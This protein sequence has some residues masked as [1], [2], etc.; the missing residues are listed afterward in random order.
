MTEKINYFTNNYN[1]TDLDPLDIKEKKV[2]L[3]LGLKNFDW[4]WEWKNDNHKGREMK[5]MVI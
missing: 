5:K 3:K 4:K 2:K 1:K